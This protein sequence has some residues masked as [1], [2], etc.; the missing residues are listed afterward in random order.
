MFNQHPTQ[1]E[2]KTH[3]VKIKL[4]LNFELSDVNDVKL[5]LHI[6]ALL[7]TTRNRLFGSRVA[8]VSSIF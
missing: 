2:I 5:K 7:K 4:N 6:F 1:I 3:L 8:N